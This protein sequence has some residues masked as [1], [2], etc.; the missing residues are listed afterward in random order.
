MH[1]LLS[2]TTFQLAINFV[3][4]LI[5]LSGCASDGGRTA[6]A[7]NEQAGPS[8]P[9]SSSI[10]DATVIPYIGS[11][12]RAAYE[13]FLRQNFHRAFAI[14]EDSAWGFATGRTPEDAVERALAGCQKHTS[15]NCRVYA[16]NLCVVYEDS[17][18]SDAPGDLAAGKAAYA[19]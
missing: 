2:V 4:A 5:M 1:R 11:K 6:P 13:D 19:S 18:C 12:G 9:V 3:A 8:S 7:K 16:L 14:S 15:E 10:S 17:D